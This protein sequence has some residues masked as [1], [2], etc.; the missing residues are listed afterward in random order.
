M[1]IIFI[2]I[3]LYNIVFWWYKPAW[4]LGLVLFMTLLEKKYIDWSRKSYGED[5]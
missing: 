5:I 1:F 4:T 2:T 3:L